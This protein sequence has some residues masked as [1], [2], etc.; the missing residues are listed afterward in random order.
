MP[1]PRLPEEKRKKIIQL[2]R[3]G[4]RI[5]V[6]AKECGVCTR[7]VQKVLAE[8]R[9]EQRTQAEL[10]D[11]ETDVLPDPVV[12]PD[13]V[14]FP[15]PIELNYDPFLIDS[16]GWWG[17]ISDLHLPCHDKRTILEWEAEVKR[18]DCRGI[19]LNGDVMDMFSVS[20]Y[21]R[22]PTK[23]K[24]I[25]EIECGRQFFRWLRSR[26]PKKRIVFKFGNHDERFIKYIVDRA[27][28]LA[29]MEE[30]RLHNLLG[31]QE[32]GIEVV[33]DKRVVQMGRLNV[34]HGHEFRGGGGVNPARWLFLRSVSTAMCGHFHRTSEHHEVGLDRRMHGVWSTGC[35][36]FLYPE[37][38]PNNK[39]NHGYAMV[40][41]HE[42]AGDF[43]V[44]NRRILPDGRVR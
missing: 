19:L 11:S 16:P 9:E 14:R 17:V 34:V 33:Q 35:A 22:I 37:Y 43:E 7:S 23:D 44:L 26:H 5:A 36:C 25:D 3:E 39:W 32:L 8:H 41:L 15:E 42:S 29:D 2:Y 38:D 31:L 30:F 1:N 27:P 24:L 40:R 13:A 18:Q 10:I 6:V 28:L 4:M 12:G 21:F 20:P